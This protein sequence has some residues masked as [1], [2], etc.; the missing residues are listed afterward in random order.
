MIKSSVGV[1]QSKEKISSRHAEGKLMRMIGDRLRDAWAPRR[2][3]D[4]ARNQSR[5]ARIIEATP[6]FIVT[7]DVRGKVLYCNRAVRQMLGMSS[8][9][10]VAKLHI[11]DIY[12]PRSCATVL[13]EGVYIANLDGEWSGEAALVTR[14]GREIPV[15][16]VIIAPPEA[17]SRHEYLALIAR[18]VQ[19]TKQAEAS[20]R[21]SEQFYRRIAEVARVGIWV[22]DANNQTSFVNPKMAHMLGYGEVE[23][24]GKPATDFIF[25]QAA[26]LLSAPGN[27]SQFLL[28]EAKDITLR[29]KDGKELPV[30]LSP[31]PLFNE[32][33]RYTGTLAMVTEIAE[34]RRSQGQTQLEN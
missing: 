9:E 20:L 10:D 6:D 31:S 11:T 13:G 5:L 2:A 19:D 33:E 14:A 24:L 23:M 12:S 25:N 3:Q 16:Q 7:M 4:R 18:D 34:S 28:E 15:S 22:I 17:N 26:A 27:A 29:R 32:Q 21:K 8:D 30:N 1:I